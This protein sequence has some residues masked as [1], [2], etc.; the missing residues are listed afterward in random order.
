MVL[1]GVLIFFAF[2]YTNLKSI[3]SK[4]PPPTAI[5]GNIT[6]SFEKIDRAVS[7]ISVLTTPS[8][9]RV[10]IDGQIRGFS[11]VK[12]TVTVG[13]H[14]IL[15]AFTS[16]KEEK[17]EIESQQGFRTIVSLKLEKDLAFVPIPNPLESPTPIPTPEN[18]VPQVEILQTSTGFL[19]VREDASAASKEIAQVSPGEKFNFVEK[20]ITSEWYKIEYQPNLFGWVSSKF[21]K[22]N[23]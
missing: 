22:I 16:Y 17:L 11:P 2:K 9:A 14:S 8:L 23:E 20:D 12:N 7:E 18:I 10:E 3:V 21:A 4:T 1:V 19:R 5:Q 6:L 13:K 15:V